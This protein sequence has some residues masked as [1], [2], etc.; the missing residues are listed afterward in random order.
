MDVGRLPE[1]RLQ[2]RV[3]CAVHRQRLGHPEGHLAGDAAAEA[4]RPSPSTFY[5]T[6]AAQKRVGELLGDGQGDKWWNV[7]SDEAVD[8]VA[9]NVMAD[10]RHHVVPWMTAQA[11][12][13]AE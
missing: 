10:I 9:E 2:R 5:G 11:T 4:E 13:N 7:R 8:P 3:D 1:V 12:S 6:W